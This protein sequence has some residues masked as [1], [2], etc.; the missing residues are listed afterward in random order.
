MSQSIFEATQPG[1]VL[2]WRGHGFEVSSMGGE[3][4]PRTLFARCSCG[5]EAYPVEED[6]GDNGPALIPPLVSF[7][8]KY[9]KNAIL[10]GERIYGD[11]DT[12]ARQCIGHME[13][14]GRLE[15]RIAKTLKRV[16]NAHGSLR[17]ATA[18]SGDGELRAESL[19]SSYIL[20]KAASDLQVLAEALSLKERMPSV[21]LPA[22]VTPGSEAAY[23]AALEAQYPG[24]HARIEA[25]KQSLQKG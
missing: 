8:E 1:E 16:E 24:W 14:G 10:H 11:W 23:E 13:L 9:G 5:Q 15:E 22:P 2:S 7:V 4:E 12:L 3:G 6:F 18:C 17:E 25:E 19:D 21:P 20:A